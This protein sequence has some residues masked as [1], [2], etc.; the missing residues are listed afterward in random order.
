[1]GL[2]TDFANEAISVNAAAPAAVTQTATYGSNDFSNGEVRTFAVL[3][4]GTT[5]GTTPTLGFQIE[6]SSDQVNWTAI[7]GMVFSAVTTPGRQ[8]VAGMR[9]KQYVRANCTTSGGTTPSIIVSIDIFSQKK[10]ASG[11]GNA[12]GYDH[13]PSN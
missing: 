5:S 7:T 8:I 12:G 1:M 3:D 9:S 10:I 11:S 4:A 2:L 6:E 13:Y